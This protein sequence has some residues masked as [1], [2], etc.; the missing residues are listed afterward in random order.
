[1]IEA[2][3]QLEALGKRSLDHQDLTPP[4]GNSPKMVGNKLKFFFFGGGG[5]NAYKIKGKEV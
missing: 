1:M 2:K 3:M 4:V 5:Q